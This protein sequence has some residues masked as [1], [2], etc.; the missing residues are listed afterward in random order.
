M[1][2]ETSGLIGGIAGTILGVGGAAFGCWASY[3]AA[4]NDAERAFLRR[5]IRVGAIGLA[6]F[7][8]VIWAVTL[9]YLSRWV[10]WG[11]MAAVFLTIP[12]A[13][14]HVNRRLEELGQ[15]TPDPDK[16]DGVDGRHHD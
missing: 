7:V 12:L 10:Y 11:A 6:V 5:L 14:R 2:G 1:D 3:R 15:Q 16:D 9:G 13:I 8:A 4:R